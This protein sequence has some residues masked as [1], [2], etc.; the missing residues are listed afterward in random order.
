MFAI[1][2][3]EL[4]SYMYSPL[5]YALIGLFFL[6]TSVSFSNSLGQT[7]TTLDNNAVN[8][9]LGFANVVLVFL[10]PVLTM[11]LFAEERKN[12]VDTLLI[13]SPVSITQIVLA[14][15]LAAFTILLILTASTLVY[16]IIVIALAKI[17]VAEMIGGYFGFILVG[18]S[19]I[20]FGIFASSLTE[21]QVLAAVISFV[22]LLLMLIMNGVQSIVGD[23]W[24]EL[25]KWFSLLDKY[26]SYQ[27][28]KF[29]LTPI[30]YYL[31]FIALFIFLTIRAIEK[32]RW[33]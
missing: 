10:V 19:F 28:G 23:T 6:I 20:A 22:G 29:I 17:S 13:S 11:K 5:P 14:K 4:R 32:R 33:S 30:V 7:T 24:Y 1:Y 2:K 18:A 8:S 31:S 26:D 16:P 27:S 3:R 15:Y 12:K 9:A 21:S 25:L